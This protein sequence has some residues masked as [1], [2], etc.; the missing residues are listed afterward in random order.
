MDSGNRW[1][2]DDRSVEITPPYT[3][4]TAVY[5]TL[6]VDDVY[7]EWADF[8]VDAWASSGGAVNRVLDVGCGTGMLAEQLVARGL[9]VSGIDASATMIDAARQRL[10]D[11]VELE[12]SAL[13][14]LTVQ[15][16]FDAA[17]STF[18]TLN[19]ISPELLEPSLRAIADV[20]R[21]GAVLVADVHTDAM[22]MFSQQN[23]EVLVDDDGWNYRVSTIT[24]VEA[25]TCESHFIAQALDDSDAFTETHVQ[26]FHSVEVF[27][28]ALREA[29]FEVLAITDEYT[30]APVT[31]QTLRATWT[32]RLV[33]PKDR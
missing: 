7:R 6:V 20:L 14:M 13:P 12:V 2:R 21:E 11:L 30:S 25:R 27:E 19:Y 23:P 29:G 5:D 10:G 1:V 4:I 28:H 15:G 32:A 33:R 31:D 26:Y 24:D 16:P 18:D 17:A 22:M 9:V 3:R 8:V